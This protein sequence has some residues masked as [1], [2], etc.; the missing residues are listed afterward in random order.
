MR[1]SGSQRKEIHEA[2]LDAFPTESSLEQMLLYELDKNLKRIAGSGNLQEIIFKIIQTAEAEGWIQQLI[3][4]AYTA[5]PGNSKLRAIAQALKINPL[6]VEPTIFENPIASNFIHSLDS[7][8]VISSAKTDLSCQVYIHRKSQWNGSANNF[9]VYCDGHKKVTISNGGASSFRIVPGTHEFYIYY[10]Q[11][12]PS[13]G[14]HGD[15]PSWS[16]GESKILKHT[17]D[18]HTNLVLQCY[19][20]S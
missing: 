4:A 17:F 7:E 9:D 6:P 2:L 19:Y 13:S 20:A 11:Y 8:K 16:I 12:H 5:N 10:K 1:L 18:E 14:Y 3:R 15:W